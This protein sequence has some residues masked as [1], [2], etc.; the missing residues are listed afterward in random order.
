MIT[1]FKCFKHVC[2]LAKLAASV[3]S[4]CSE[5]PHGQNLETPMRNKMS[6]PSRAA[7]RKQGLVFSHRCS[8]F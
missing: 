4:E 5:W 1:A 8:I 3:V 6:S 2:V 7:L